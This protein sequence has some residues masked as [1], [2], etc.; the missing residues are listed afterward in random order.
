MLRIINEPTAACLAYGLEKAGKELKILVFDFGGGTLDVTIME[1]WKEGGFKVVATSGDTQ[2]GGTDMDNAFVDYIEKEFQRQTGIDL[3]KDTMATQRV[4]EAAE[5]A[6][7]E[8]SSTL[9]TDI[10]LPFI[11]A[12]ATG[13]KHLT[14]T[15]NRAKLEELIGPIVAAL[16]RPAGDRAAGRD[17]R[18]R[19]GRRAV[20]RERRGHRQDHH[21]R[22]S[23]PHAHRAEV[24]RG[25]LRQEDRARRRPHGVRGHGRGH[26]G[27]DHQGRGEGRPPPGR[28]PAVPR[29]RDPRRREHQAHR[30]QHD[31][32]HAQERD[33]L[34][35][36]G[37]P[38][39]GDH[40]GPPGRAAHG[41]R[42]RGAGPVQP[43]RASP[44][45]RAGVPQVEVSF[46]ID[47]NGIVER[48][49]QGPGH[50]ASSSPS[51]SRRPKKLSKEEIE[52]MVRQA[53][54]F[55]ADDAKRKEEVE[56]VNQ[57]DTLAYSVEKSLKDYGDKVS[58]AERADI[59]AK[60]ND[61]Q[62]AIKDKN[63][64]RIKKGMEELTK[65]SHKLAE[66]V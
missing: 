2:L 60:L 39:R 6:K 22:R 35:R 37:Q 48:R 27:G 8:L 56:A 36:G 51:R 62:T 10:N 32:P 31:H 9:S 54:Q 25:L 34:H 53:E 33:L 14:M 45:R 24:R 23:D 40:P 19:Q 42:Q 43:R 11:T 55:A 20:Q 26:P 28:H 41:Q 59:E 13:P 63:L 61:L 18:V 38:D 65:A 64:D 5:K 46:D 52:K 58:Q 47:A 49:G 29:H 30:A 66:E 4:R 7:V 50:R 3:K 1:M 57:A 15:V 12:D 16:P 44:R 21:G 17:G